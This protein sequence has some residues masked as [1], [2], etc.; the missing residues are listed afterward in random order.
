M[1]KIDN[2]HISP[3]MLGVLTTTAIALFVGAEKFG[4]LNG[5]LKIIEGKTDFKELRIQ[6]DKISKTINEQILDAE[7]QLKTL[8][9]RLNAHKNNFSMKYSAIENKFNNNLEV[10]LSSASKQIE[11]LSFSYNR[12]IDKSK[13]RKENILQELRYGID[14][15]LYRANNLTK[16][17]QRNLRQL[18]IE[19]AKKERQLSKLKQITASEIRIKEEQL[20]SLKRKYNIQLPPNN[21]INNDPKPNKIQVKSEESKPQRQ[22]KVTRE[23]YYTIQVAALKNSKKAKKIHKD[24]IKA[25]FPSFLIKNE[26]S[27]LI[28][29]R[30]GK[31]R[32]RGEAVN[33]HRKMKR[34]FPRGRNVK[35]SYIKQLSAE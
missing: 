7:R 29:V 22:I 9:D 20:S 25:G 10:K 17:L 3:A 11:S 27:G 18:K 26:V 34:R 24:L 31:C 19:V 5:R 28:Y 23:K 1:K 30:V 33:I 6:Q 16:K 32:T 21:Y 12:E 13:V 8:K 14:H 15:E 4:D 2:I 35:N